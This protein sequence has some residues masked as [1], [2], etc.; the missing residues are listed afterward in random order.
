MVDYDFSTLNDKEFEALCIDL[1][2]AKLNKQFTRFKAGRDGGIDGRYFSSNG[3]IEII[4]CKHYLKSGFDTLL[5][6]LKNIEQPKVNKLSP[7]KYYVVTSVPLNPANKTK[8]RALFTSYMPNDDYVIGQE[9]LNILLGRHPDIEKRYFKLWLSSV[10]VLN[11]I[12]NN[13]IVGRS[14]YFIN[15]IKA[16]SGLYVFSD[17]VSK[18]AKIIKEKSTVI[19]EG[20]P[21]IGKS[22]LAE[23]LI[24]MGIKSGYKI[25]K[26]ENAIN[27]AEKIFS[28]SDEEK[29]L[30]YFD[31]F[32]GSNYLTAIEN[33]KDSHIV[34]FIERISKSKN[35]KFILTSRTNII[36]RAKSLSDIFNNAK[37][38]QN[39]YIM[40]VTQLSEMNKAK[41]LYNHIWY[42]KLPEDYIDQLYEDRRYL[43]IIQHK[44]FNPRIIEFITDISRLS[45]ISANQYWANIEEKLNNPAEIWANT[46]DN[47]SNDYIR[48]LVILIVFS[49]GKITERE[50]IT[51]YNKI[52]ER[53]TK[54]ETQ[55]TDFSS[56][57]KIA[58]NYFINRSIESSTKETSYSLFNPSITDF[59]L[60]RYY[61]DTTLLFNVLLAL[62]STQSISVISN[63]SLAD[64]L[65]K[66]VIEKIIKKLFNALDVNDYGYEFSF[67]FIICLIYHLQKNDATDQISK[68]QTFIKYVLQEKPNLAN[69][70]LGSKLKFA[71]L[72]LSDAQNYILLG[73]WISILLKFDDYNF[74]KNYEKLDLL[75]YTLT[76]IKEANIEDSIDEIS[77]FV[78][79]LNKIGIHDE[80]LI[81]SLNEY[82]NKDFLPCYINFVVYET[83]D[84]NAIETYQEINYC[85]GSDEGISIVEESIECFIL[86]AINDTLPYLNKLSGIYIDEDAILSVIDIDTIKQKLIK[87]Y[88]YEYEPPDDYYD[89]HERAT[90]Y[91]NVEE[92]FE[93]NR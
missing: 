72:S 5:H 78:E 20:E 41:I 38:N 76:M 3:S 7:Q 73:F 67:D 8:I 60:K 10:N 89:R 11:T 25:Y 58:V 52:S 62:R 34:N 74:I 43:K 75:S 91:S 51:S 47:Q 14:D 31:D 65:D 87:D 88:G 55:N 46:F 64:S 56:S 70:E 59:I 1:L 85:D 57:M 37:T 4:Q 48:A 35:K 54:T 26:I 19:I 12:L 24:L 83:I 6:T 93:R 33:H 13:A 49:N 27:E 17:I 29:Q 92:L 69:N 61:S 36:Q 42:S 22:T 68:I 16:K 15:K 45:G 40:S 30:F 18:A 39:E 86:D 44:N 82:I 32:L 79:L 21:G 23:M 50:L 66:K 77:N 84:I 81:N 63:A 90:D 2:S 80:L 28:I 9:Q 71:K 53:I